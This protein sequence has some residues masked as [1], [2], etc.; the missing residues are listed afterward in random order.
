MCVCVCVCVRLLNISAIRRLRLGRWVKT[1]TIWWWNEHRMN[2]WSV[3]VCV[4]VC[5][6]VRV[7]VC[8][9]KKKK[10]KVSEEKIPTILSKRMR[11]WTQILQTQFFEN[12]K[13]ASLLLEPCS[14]IHQSYHLQASPGGDGTEI[15]SW[16]PEIR[17][18][19]RNSISLKA[20]F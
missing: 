6:R 10:W 7:C 18:W 5:V 20:Y 19:V 3:C 9:L 1:K 13:F 2:E 4:C 11:C 8:K 17:C 14:Y 12:E 15:R 16:G